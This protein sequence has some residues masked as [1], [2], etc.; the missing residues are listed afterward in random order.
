MFSTAV[1]D[2]CQYEPYRYSGDICPHVAQTL[3]WSLTHNERMV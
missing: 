3:E 2:L 1:L